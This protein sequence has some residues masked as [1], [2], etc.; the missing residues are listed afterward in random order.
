MK[1]QNYEN[2][3]KIDPAFHVGIALLSLITLILTI[4]FF[5]KNVGEET[6]ISFL[7]LFIVLTMILIGVKLRTYAL[8]VQDRVIRTEENFRY[9]RLTGDSLASALSLK[10]II[11][12]RFAPD[13][14][15][16]A[17]VERTLSENLSPTDIK[18]AV[19]NWRADHHRV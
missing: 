16:P 5:V 7:V 18:K 4:T 14:E 11:A 17:L 8:Q 1:Q 19:Q 15:F 12:L 3:S 10:Q 6:L 13:E 2:H 9:Y